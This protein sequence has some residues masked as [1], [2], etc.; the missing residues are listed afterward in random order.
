MGDEG[1]DGGRMRDE[2]RRKEGWVLS[3]KRDPLRMGNRF[4]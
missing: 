2:K 4:V 3:R 1:K